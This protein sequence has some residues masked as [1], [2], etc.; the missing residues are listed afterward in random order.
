MTKTKLLE[1]IDLLPDEFKLDELF[2]RLIFMHKVELGL[3]QSDEGKVVST[4][5]A[6]KRLEK[7]LK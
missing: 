5:E 3:T 7:W 6:K 4:E 1:T 2:E